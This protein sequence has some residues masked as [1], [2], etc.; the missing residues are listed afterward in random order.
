MNAADRLRLMSRPG[1]HL[2]E[3]MAQ[4]LNGL[5][6]MFDLVNV[7]DDPALEAA[8]GHF[9]PVLLKGDAEVARAPQSGM[10]LIRSLHR[11][12]VI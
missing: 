12:G 7:E 6:L 4:D 11:A 2:C 1:C 8:Y 5:G 9:I 10:T 3:A